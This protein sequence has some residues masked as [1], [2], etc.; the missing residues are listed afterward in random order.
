MKIDIEPDLKFSKEIKDP[1]LT[2]EVQESRL[3]RNKSSLKS[4]VFM[5]ASGFERK[6]QPEISEIKTTIIALD[7]KK[8]PEIKFTLKEI[9]VKFNASGILL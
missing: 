5:E 4:L 2:T 9:P 3:Q 8:K 7:D 6:Q 1:T